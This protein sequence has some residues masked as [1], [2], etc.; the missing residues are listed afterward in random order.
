MPPQRDGLL[1]GVAILTVV[2]SW[3]VLNMVFTLQYADQHRG[4]GRAGIDVG[5]SNAEELHVP[6]LR[7]RRLHHR[8][9]L[10]GF[11]HHV[12]QSADSPHGALPRLLSYMFGV[13]TVG[14]SVNLITGLIRSISAVRKAV[15]IRPPRPLLAECEYVGLDAG[16]EEGYL[17]G[18]V[19][20]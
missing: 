16:C 11:R 5:D 12:A 6:R 9:V 14:G 20:N 15:C 10:P 7:P 19:V 13:A 3:T 4:F 1:I 2:L 18:A 17:E 8:H